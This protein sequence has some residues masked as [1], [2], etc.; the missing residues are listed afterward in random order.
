MRVDRPVAGTGEG[1][2]S[3]HSRPKNERHATD[4]KKPRLGGSSACSS[5]CQTR[6]LFFAGT[7]ASCQK[8]GGEVNPPPPPNTGKP[9]IS[10]DSPAS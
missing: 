2:P 5:G 10:S 3:P 1:F 6:P 8:G 7:R 4:V 9:R